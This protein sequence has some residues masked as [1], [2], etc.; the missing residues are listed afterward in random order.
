MRALG[1]VMILSGSVWIAAADV[2][3]RRRTLRLL[4]ELEAALRDMET[5]IRWK[6]QML[7]DIIAQQAKRPLCGAYFAAVSDG[8]RLEIPLQDAWQSAFAALKM[9][10][11]RECLQNTELCGD[12]KR[13]MGNLNMAAEHLHKL[14]E[15]LHAKQRQEE[16]LHLTVVFSA[17]GMLIILLI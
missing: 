1:I 5:G 7:P 15:E 14:H 13:I 4:G 12:E 11:A 9:Q 8:L 2:R 6:R 16:K 17:A 10:E 3:S